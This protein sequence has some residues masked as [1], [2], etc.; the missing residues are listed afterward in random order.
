MIPVPVRQPIDHCGRCGQPG[1][2][3]DGEKL[4]T[5]PA[6]GWHFYQ[7]SA[8]AVVAVLEL[9]DTILLTRRARDPGTGL[10]DLPGGFVDNGESAERALAR[11]LDEELGLTLPESAF[12]YLFSLPNTYPYREVLYHTTDFFYRASIGAVPAIVDRD[13]ITALEFAD[14]RK[15]A[16]ASIALP[17]IRAGLARYAAA[18]T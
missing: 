8:A 15:I 5:C 13:E 6:C 17:S 1:V 12:H 14:P 2:R 9:G 10:L 18:R 16:P 4:F 11:E 7:N 3:F